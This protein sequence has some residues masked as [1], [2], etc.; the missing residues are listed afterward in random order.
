MF[1]WVRTLRKRCLTCPRNKQVR[2]DQNTAP[3]EKCEEKVLYPFHTV[4]ID[5]LGP[6]NPMIHGRHHCSL[7]EDAFLHFI[8]VS[9][10]KF[11][12][13]THTIKAKSIFTTSFEI[14]QKLV[15]DRGTSAKIFDFFVFLPNLA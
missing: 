1:K 8:Q 15:C 14:P 13:A 9:P 11:A 5:H 12:D 10:E 6:L 7:V 4:H 2:K 3:N